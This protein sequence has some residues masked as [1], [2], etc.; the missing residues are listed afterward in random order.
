MASPRLSPDKDSVEFIAG[1]GAPLLLLCDHASNALPKA[2]GT[3]GLPAA[4]L[5]RHIAYDIGAAAV[6]RALA[7]R[8][9]AAALLAGFSRL[10]I[11][12]NRGPD[13]PT[14]VMKLSDGAVIPGNAEADAVEVERRIAAFHAPYHAAIA[15]TI[16]AMLDRGVRPAILSIHSFTPRWK[17]IARPWHAAVL[18]D[19]DPRLAQPLIAAL[20]AAGGLLVGDNEPYDGALEND[21][22]YR[23]ATARGLP[24]A[25]IEIRQDL[26]GDDA[27]AAHWADR[28]ASV[29]APLLDNA[30]LREIK[31]FGSRAGRGRR[32]APRGGHPMTDIDDRTMTELEAAVFRR[33][34]EHLRNHP[35]VQNIELMNLAGFCRNCLSNWLKDA[36]DEH[37]LPLS[38]DASREHVYGMPYGEW[39][40]RH[41][42]AASPAQLAA[43]AAKGGG[44]GA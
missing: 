33:L 31:F 17:G 40:A 28:L 11:D 39:K 5:D 14:L 8:L 2:Y 42:S 12:P 24:H 32:F 23:H 35:E 6:T 19:R 29:V 20:R 16:E 13:D 3:L 21:T 30:D 9:G 26:I 1:G 38:K 18:W 22:L 37:G 34:V 44:S 7:Q 15:R 4:E 36:A 25:L 43:F 27:G 10:L 41:Q